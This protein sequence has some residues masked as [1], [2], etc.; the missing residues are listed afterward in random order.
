MII[1]LQRYKFASNP[2]FLKHCKKGFWIPL[3]GSNYILFRY[4]RAAII[5]VIIAKTPKAV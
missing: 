4:V 3:K 2:Q 5:S 1:I